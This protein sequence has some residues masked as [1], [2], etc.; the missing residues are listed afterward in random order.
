MNIGENTKKIRTNLGLTQT[1]LA[2]RV[3]IGRSMLAQIERGTKTMT[4]PVAAEIAKALNCSIY[5][6]LG[7]EEQ[8]CKTA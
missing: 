7:E 5:E 4:L 8:Q 2:E 6:L 1:E 3:G